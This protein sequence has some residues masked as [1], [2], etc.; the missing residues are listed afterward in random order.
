MNIKNKKNEN[1]PEG[2]PFDFDEIFAN[3]PTETETVVDLPSR[4]KFYGTSKITI[5]P[6]T[7]EDEKAMVL[8]KKNKGDVINTLLGR[9]VQGVNVFD[10]LL[11]DKLHLILKLREISYGDN[12]SATVTCAKCQAD[13]KLNFTL[14]DLP[15][16]QIPETLQMENEI[17]LPV[18]KV[19]VKVRIPTI[20]DEKYLNS[21]VSIFDNLWRFVTAI[22]DS[23]DPVII[24][25][26]LSDPRVPLKDMHAIMDMVSLK[27]YGVQTT[28]RFDCDKCSHPNIITLPIGP[29]FF[30]VN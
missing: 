7:F 26:F 14:S 3:L 28:V 18:T 4:S 15:I 25:K 8:S 19:K 1:L 11:L 24:S 16:E 5:R 9:C 17:T 2:K 6:M 12:Y 27:E 20:D 10:L 30:T 22:Q 23:D 13:N 29:D 21:E